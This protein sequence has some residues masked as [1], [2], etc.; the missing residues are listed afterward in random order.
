MDRAQQREQKKQSKRQEIRAQRLRQQRRL[1]L[2]WSGAGAIVLLLAAVFVW[3]GYAQGTLVS[4]GEKVQVM[5][6]YTTHVKD[7]TD[8][9]P[10]ATNPP[11]GGRHFA[12]P[13][14]AGF[15][16]DAFAASL[17]Q[18]PEGHL[19]HSLEHGYVIFWYNCDLLSAQ[20]CTTLKTQIRQ[21]MDKF[22]GKKLIAYPWKT[23]DV[24]VA[25]TS[26]DRLQR[27]T[28]FDPALAERFIRANMNKSPEPNAQ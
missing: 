27:F 19:V 15:Y 25:M 13:V 10:Y 14:L 24:P 5:P 7:G 1:A 2:I 6:G 26:W 9:G 22:G 28:T 4:V 16:D 3:R 12:D 21:V 20:E 8:P 23:M 11:A 17:G 18:Y